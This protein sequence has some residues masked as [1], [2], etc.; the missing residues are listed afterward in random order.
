[1]KTHSSIHRIVLNVAI[2][3]IV[4]RNIMHFRSLKNQFGVTV[5]KE[6]KITNK[7]VAATVMLMLEMMMSMTTM[8]TRTTKSPGK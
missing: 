2:Y 7:D 4:K 1:M 3:S 8:T 5:K 6:M